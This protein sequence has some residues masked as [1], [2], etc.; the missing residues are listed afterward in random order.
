MLAP[1][2]ELS[3]RA[4]RELIHGFFASINKQYGSGSPPAFQAKDVVYFTEMISAPGLLANGPFEKWY[5]ENGPCPQQLVYQLVG[6]D[7]DQLVKAAALLDRKECFGIDI[8][9]GCSAPAITRTGAGVRWME[10]PDKAAGLIERIRRITKKQLSV[11]IRLCPKTGRKNNFFHETP[12]NKT[13][14][15]SLQELPFL[16]R[17]CRS[18]ED[19]GLDLIILHPRRAEEKFKRRARWEYVEALRKELTIPIAGNGDIDSTEELFGKAADGPVMAGRFLVRQP[20]AFAAVS[21]FSESTPNNSPKNNL[22]IN[23]EE[24]GLRFLELL[25]RYQPLEF[26][27]S[28]AFRFFRYFCGNA[29]WAEHLRNI[30]N[31]QESLAGIEKVWREYFA[32]R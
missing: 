11:K 1:M 5:L 10:S 6:S 12:D 32:K 15:N 30:I 16:L 13:K 25:A 21:I 17:F 9:M 2:A 7:A 3:H 29:A 22:K 31:R 23:I 26:H 20:W 27:L 4:L 18:L 14:I 8:N 24:T 19:A 28:R